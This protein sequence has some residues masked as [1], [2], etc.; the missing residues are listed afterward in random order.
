[1]YSNEKKKQTVPWELNKA[2]HYD[3]IPLERV[4]NIMGDE[5]MNQLEFQYLLRSQKSNYEQLLKMTDD[6]KLIEQINI[7]IQIIN[8]TL[9]SGK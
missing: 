6:E 3:T 4:V 2:L 5:E 7:Y 9:L 1:M 8:D